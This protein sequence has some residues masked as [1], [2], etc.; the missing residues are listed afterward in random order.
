MCIC[1][2]EI[3]SSLSSASVDLG[4]SWICAEV[5]ASSAVAV[6]TD[7]GLADSATGG[8]GEGAVR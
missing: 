3:P 5:R 1:D 6:Q 4:S 7:A 2:C 8:A